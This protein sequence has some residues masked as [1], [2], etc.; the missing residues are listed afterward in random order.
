MSEHTPGPWKIL[1]DPKIMETLPGFK[2]CYDLLN[3]AISKAKGE[4]R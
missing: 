1:A 3:Q 2:D 4:A